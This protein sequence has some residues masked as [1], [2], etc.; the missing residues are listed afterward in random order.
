MDAFDQ[1]I[2]ITGLPRSGTSMVTGLLAQSGIWVGSTIAGGPSNPKGFFEH[3]QIREVVI[4]GILRSIDCD[5]LGIKKLPPADFSEEINFNN[6]TQETI[7]LQDFIHGVIRQDGY[8]DQQRWAYKEP[9]LA[10]LWQ[11]FQNAFPHAIWLIVERN[12]DSVIRSCLNTHFM[13]QH[14]LEESFWQEVLDQYGLRLQR[15]K[16]SDARVW[17]ISADNLMAGDHK[18]IQGFCEFANLNI[19]SAKVAAEFLEKRHWHY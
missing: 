13:Q 14:S 6:G 4:K 7:S 17:T 18:E 9:K 1:P 3:A 19:N 16:D 8:N 12:R 5:P 10:L 2:F 15:L 11:S